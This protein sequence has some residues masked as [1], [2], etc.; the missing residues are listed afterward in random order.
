MLVGSVRLRGDLK[1]EI[2]NNRISLGNM[3]G[4]LKLTM[5]REKKLTNKTW[6]PPEY[7]TNDSHYSLQ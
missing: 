2:L 5:R 7:S 3:E 4:I 1:G 6:K